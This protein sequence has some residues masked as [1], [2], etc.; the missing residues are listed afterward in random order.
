MVKTNAIRI[1]ESKGVQ[2]DTL[3]YLYD[4]S[5]LSVG[6]IAHDLHMPVAQIFKTLVAKGDKTGVLIAVIPG[7]RELDYKILAKASGNK[8]VTL[9]ALK[10]LQPLT[11]YIRGG[12]SPVGMKKPY[13][14]FIHSSAKDWDRI[15]VNAGKTGLLIGVAPDQLKEVTMGIWIEEPTTPPYC[16]RH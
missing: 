7:D 1:L 14:V 4:T 11:G 16:G 3:E 6:K 15:Y 9:V 10:E 8:K 5:D 13:P 2:Y 12:C